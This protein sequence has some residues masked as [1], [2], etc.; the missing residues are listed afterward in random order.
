MSGR[1]QVL[2]VRA[3]HRRYEYIFMMWTT[4]QEWASESNAFCIA[5]LCLF[6]A[7]HVSAYTNV[8]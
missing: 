6:L 5:F 4:I 2:T 1:R 7:P 3:S 8:A